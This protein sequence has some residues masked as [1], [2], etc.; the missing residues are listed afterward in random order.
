[1]IRIADRGRNDDRLTPLVVSAGSV[2]GAAGR[3][4]GLGL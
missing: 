4:L 3:A 2:V 1:M